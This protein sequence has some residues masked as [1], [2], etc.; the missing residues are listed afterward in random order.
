MKKRC[1]IWFLLLFC[2]NALAQQP[3]RDTASDMDSATF[4]PAAD[5]D[6]RAEKYFDR[7][8]SL[9]G[10]TVELRGVSQRT[11]DS[12][13]KDGEFWYAGKT[14]KKRNIVLPS[15]WMSMTTLVIIVVIFLV[16]LGWYLFRSNIISRRGFG[17]RA[18]NADGV[19]QDIFS[20]D[21]SAGVQA[22]ILS[23]DYR[24]AVRLLF[25]KALRDLSISKI[26]RYKADKTNFVYMAELAATPYYLDF[27]RLARNFEYTW[28]G[29][30][31]VDAEKFAIIRADFE[32]FSQKIS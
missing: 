12:I 7:A 24:L 15:R 23:G 30:F 28:Y 22:A 10:D 18:M 5:S 14:F 32:N 19:E 20:I 25:L 6:S 3:V 27:F 31:E 29:K 13:K 8:T 2:V 26:I 9:A 11:L 16:I 4:S 21:Y 17:S 1:G